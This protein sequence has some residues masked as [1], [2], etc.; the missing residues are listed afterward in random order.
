VHEPQAVARPSTAQRGFSTS[1]DEATDRS[2]TSVASV[3]NADRHRALFALAL[4]VPAQSIG[5]IAMLHLFP[6]PSGKVVAVFTRVWLICLPF[7]WVTW[8]EGRLPGPIVIRPKGLG[9]GL[10]T[11]VACLA[12]IVA[13]TWLL[14]DSINLTALRARASLTGFDRHSLF[15]IACFYV[16]AINPLLEEYVWRWFVLRQV[17]RIVSQGLPTLGAAVIASLLFTIHHVIALAAW[18][19][20]QWNILGC[21]AVFVAGFLWSRLYQRYRSIW[22]GYISHA[23]ADLAIMIS[24]ADLLYR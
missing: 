17:E 23:F 8:V 18:V 3:T 11:G 22:P 2:A 4:L 21:I 19:T 10:G 20:W 7:I 12:V 1:M 9:I 24:A 15:A 13:A 6:G 16:V 14:R 5:L